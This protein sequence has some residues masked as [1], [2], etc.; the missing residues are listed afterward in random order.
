MKEKQGKGTLINF[1]NINIPKDDEEILDGETF[2]QAV[3]EC[4]LNLLG[5]NEGGENPLTI[6]N[7]FNHQQQDRT[8]M[9]RAHSHEDLYQHIHF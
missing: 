6:H 8:L 2:F 9:I 3:E 7:I 1:Q 4:L 5:L